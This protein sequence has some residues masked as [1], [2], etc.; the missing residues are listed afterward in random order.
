METTKSFL[1][2]QGIFHAA[3]FVV[4]GVLPFHLVLTYV[5]VHKTSLGGNGAMVALA[6]SDWLIG[7]LL[8]VW[9]WNS[10]AKEC[11]GGWDR[12]ALNGWGV[13]LHIM[14]PCIFV[15]V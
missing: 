4:L 8:V 1:Q 14:I 9:I 15:S 10:K 11:W 12:R 3:T 6:C 2:A 7:L 13:Y 5:L